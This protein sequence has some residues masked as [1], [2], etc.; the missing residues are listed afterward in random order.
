MGTQDIIQAVANLDKSLAQANKT[1]R[2]LSRAG[3]THNK[4]IDRYYEALAQ[5]FKAYIK[6]KA[7]GRE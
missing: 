3:K 5:L 4:A 2:A 1:Y 7:E 6:A